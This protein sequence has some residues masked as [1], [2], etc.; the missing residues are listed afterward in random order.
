M[1][2]EKLN[3]T[4]V[5]KPPTREELKGIVRST[6][7]A[8]GQFVGMLVFTG[9]MYT[10]YDIIQNNGA[11]I[12]PILDYIEYTVQPAFTNLWNYIPWLQIMSTL[13]IWLFFLILETFESVVDTKTMIYS[14]HMSRKRHREEYLKDV[15]S[16][17]ILRTLIL[18]AVAG[19]ILY[20]TPSIVW[21]IIWVIVVVVPIGLVLNFEMVDYLA[22]L[23]TTLPETLTYTRGQIE[24]RERI[25]DYL[26]S[27]E[28][29]RKDYS[30]KDYER[31]S[32]HVSQGVANILYAINH[33]PFEEW[34]HFEDYIKNG[35]DSQLFAIRI[36]NPG[37]ELATYLGGSGT[38]GFREPFYSSY[39]EHL[40][41]WD[42]EV[43]EYRIDLERQKRPE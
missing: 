20:F 38:L 5:I 8:V 27:I 39:Y 26:E 31:D 41:E 7:K 22:Y 11:H 16:Y 1:D 24:V 36:P 10:V 33:R 28:W 40:R 2:K 19:T 34:A 29:E 43:N 15:V 13:A 3:R 37:P 9:M 21:G 25:L 6:L 4:K 14:W 12:R 18:L 23:N 42:F 17:I 30:K 35:H 32:E